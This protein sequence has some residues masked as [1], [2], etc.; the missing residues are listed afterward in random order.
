MSMQPNPNKP[1]NTFTVSCKNPFRLDGGIIVIPNSVCHVTFNGTE[2]C[3]VTVEDLE[4]QKVMK[5]LDLPKH[6]PAFNI[7]NEEY[8]HKSVTNNKV[9]NSGYDQYG[10]PSWITLGIEDMQDAGRTGVTENDAV[11][12]VKKPLSSQ[13]QDVRRREADKAKW[14]KKTD[15]ADA[16]RK[17][18]SP[19]TNRF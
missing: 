18:G 11:E 9:G 5:C 13:E 10:A 7:P 12:K 8:L 3:V 19:K 16:W 6:F 15:A 1:K 17:A 4:G 2:D 14:A